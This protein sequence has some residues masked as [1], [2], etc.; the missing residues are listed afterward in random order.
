MRLT[1]LHHPTGDC[2]TL[3]WLSII[4]K[5]EMFIATQVHSWSGATSTSTGTQG[6]NAVRQT[7]IQ[8]SANFTG[9][10]LAARLDS[11]QAR[12]RAQRA[13]A[14]PVSISCSNRPA[15]PS[16]ASPSASS[17][18]TTATPYAL[19]ATAAGMAAAAA[20][21]S[22]SITDRPS[23]TQVA[24]PDSSDVSSSNGS[25]SYSST[26][27][28]GATTQALQGLS[29]GDKLKALRQVQQ[30][31]R[32]ALQQVSSPSSPYYV[33]APK[34]IDIRMYDQLV[35]AHNK[36]SK[37]LGESNAHLEVLQEQVDQC[38]EDLMAAFEL[39]KQVSSIW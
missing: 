22:I 26:T 37:K 19:S 21:T 24:S 8:E 2:G 38:N 20:S 28:Q 27:L 9:A 30:A 23:S 18:P 6:E 39:L 1:G 34:T 33:N 12:L 31:S 14:T 5:T 7:Y 15:A 10:E 3:H 11:M 29:A 35:A 32:Q 36:L 4:V 16:L 13:P 17:F 25:G